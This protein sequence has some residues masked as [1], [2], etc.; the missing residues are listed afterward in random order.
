MKID[1]DHFKGAQMADI[2][3]GILEE[4]EALHIIQVL[5]PKFSKDGNRYC[6]LYGELPND[7]IVGFGETPRQAAQDFADNYRFQKA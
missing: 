1:F 2:Q 4:Q 6:F 3:M 5:Q 7:C